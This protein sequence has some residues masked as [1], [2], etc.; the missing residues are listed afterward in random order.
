MSRLS[1]LIGC[2][3]DRPMIHPSSYRAR[4]VA[5]IMILLL[6]TVLSMLVLQFSL[7]ARQKVDQSQVLIDRA[8]AGL[9][10]KSLESVLLF[11]LL[12][13]PRLV[14]DEAASL[15]WNFANQPFLI[16]N[17]E[18]RIQDMTGLDP[19]PAP[20]VDPGQFEQVLQV[21]GVGAETARE[22]GQRLATA[23]VEP[24]RFALQT[25]EE[26]SAVT[27][28]SA[29]I[30]RRLADVMTFYPTTV[31]NPGTAPQALLRV[32]YGDLT[33]RSLWE[34]REAGELT[35]E[36]FARLTGETDDLLISFV[37]GPGFKLTLTS[38]VGEVKL[39]RSSVWTVYPASEGD[40]IT[41]WSTEKIVFEEPKADEA[42]RSN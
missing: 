38:R 30:V 24:T 28:L 32:R 4:G 29:P 39:G 40:P 18:V 41:L 42:W 14:T 25:M 37:P 8:Q 22:A 7:T 31:F 27:G 5:L 34:R 17:D 35:V 9:R 3:A 20:G 23:Q 16:E 13:E 12:T 33:A 21:L 26:V 2:A 15:P 10:L 6:M 19:L 36:E 1:R 11:S